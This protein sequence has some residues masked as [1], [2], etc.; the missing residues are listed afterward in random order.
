MKKMGIMGGTFDPIHNGHIM[1]GLCAHEEYGLDQVYYMPSGQPPHKRGRRVTDASMRAEMVRLAIEPYPQFAFSDFEIKREGNTY[2]AQT[3]ALLNQLHP[4]TQYYFIIGADSLFQILNWY[5]PE[6]I[7]KRAVLLAAARDHTSDS[8]LKER[9][10]FLGE[11]YGAD[12]RL[13][14]SPNIDVSSEELRGRI[15]CQQSV[16]GYLDSRVEAYIRRHRLYLMDETTGDRK[17]GKSNA[18]ADQSTAG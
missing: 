10:S 7:F 1:L 4:D 17:D 18:D 12:I 9:I 11:H 3:L 8:Q 6:E 16:E 14:H 15:G 13:L 5:H 2:T